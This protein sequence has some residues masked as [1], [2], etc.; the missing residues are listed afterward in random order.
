MCCSTRNIQTQLGVLLPDNVTDWRQYR[1]SGIQQGEH[2]LAELKR[3]RENRV[4]KYARYR[5]WYKTDAKISHKST[6]ELSTFDTTSSPYYNP[7]RHYEEILPGR[8]TSHSTLPRLTEW[9]SSRSP[10]SQFGQSLVNDLGDNRSSDKEVVATGHSDA[11]RNS[12]HLKYHVLG[13]RSCNCG[14]CIIQHNTSQVSIRR[15]VSYS[16]SAR[17]KPGWLHESRNHSIKF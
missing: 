4:S 8:I 1:P 2:R 16:P 6:P 17:G 11:Y 3:C 5:S 9:Y 14:E 7:S 15:R 10:T 13:N 12:V